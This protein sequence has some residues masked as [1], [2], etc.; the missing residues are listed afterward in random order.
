MTRAY[1]VSDL[2]LTSAEDSRTRLFER[3]LAAVAADQQATHLFLLGDIFDLWIGGHDYFAGRYA[4]VVHAIEALRG[5]GIEVHYFEGNHDLHLR[6][7]WQRRLAVEVHPGPIAIEIA[8]HRL[9]LEHGDEM[10]PD[11]RGYLFLR[12]FLRTPLMRL[13]ILNLPGRVVAWIGERASAHSRN[14]TSGTKTISP[15]DAIAKIRLHAAKVHA[16]ES[17]DIIVSGHVH[18]RDDATIES[19]AGRARSV[20]L[21][22]WLDRPCCFRLDAEGGELIELGHD[23]VAQLASPD[24][25]VATNTS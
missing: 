9:R 7:F 6:P 5:R 1:F 18:V 3:F 2:H 14:Y 10:D 24:E 11:D 13:L 19:A 25:A 16:E 15:E 17:F 8:G 4:G 23:D 21:G 22:T 12:W 20:N